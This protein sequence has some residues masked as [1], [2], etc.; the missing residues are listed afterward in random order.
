MLF[1]AL[2][3][4]EWPPRDA[5]L[6]LA[7]SMA[8]IV[9]VINPDFRHVSAGDLAGLLSGIFGG[10]AITAIKDL[11]RTESALLIFFSLCLCGSVITGVGLLLGASN[12]VPLAPIRWPVGHALWLLLLGVC[13]CS[14]VGQVLATWGYRYTSTVLGSLILLSIVPMNLM[15]GVLFFGEPLHW[16][17]G[18]GSLMVLAAGI[19]LTI[20]EARAADALTADALYVL[21]DTAID[22]ASTN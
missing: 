19:Y 22:P 11:R 3:L 5:L 2:F 8:G 18:L 10:L 6:A 17:N 20:S 9:I 16:Y 15:A 12:V 4:R 14:T 21:E 1:S 13:G 7:V